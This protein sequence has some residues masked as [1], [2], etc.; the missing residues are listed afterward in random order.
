M[1]QEFKYL[2]GFNNGYLIK[3]YQS[4]LSDKLASNL[5]ME[6]DFFQGLIDGKEQ[7]EIDSMHEELLQIKSMR[8]GKQNSERDFLNY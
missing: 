8:N 2:Q 3:K 1:D 4:V 6:N 5:T 7:F